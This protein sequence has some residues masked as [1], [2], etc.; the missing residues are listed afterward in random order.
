[1][2]ELITAAASLMILMTFVLQFAADQSFAVKSAAAEAI[3][4][5]AAGENGCRRRREDGKRT[6]ERDVRAVGMQYK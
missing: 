6:A 1:M 2:K 3:C 4:R 5:R